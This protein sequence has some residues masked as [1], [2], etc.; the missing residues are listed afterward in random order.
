MVITGL[1]VV[2]VWA[3]FELSVAVDWRVEVVSGSGNSVVGLL[4]ELLVL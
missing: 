3:E 2:F 1:P 4:A